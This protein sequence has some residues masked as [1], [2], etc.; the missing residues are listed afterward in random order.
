MF[1]GPEAD[2]TLTENAQPA[3]LA[4]SMAV[5]RVLVRGA[6]LDMKRVAFVA[7]HSLGEYS[8]LAAA[9]AFAL[10]DAARLL[11]RRPN[12][13]RAAAHRCAETAKSK[14]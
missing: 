10:P 11:K 9:E 14:S 3:L 5:I 8:A 7:G 12:R 4:M 1:E 13:M 6:G 2:L